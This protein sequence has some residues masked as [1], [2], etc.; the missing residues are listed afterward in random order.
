M[1]E[2]HLKYA[3]LWGKRIEIVVESGNSITRGAR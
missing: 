2:I 1:E 3:G